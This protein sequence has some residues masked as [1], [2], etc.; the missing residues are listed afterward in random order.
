[1]L[2]ILRINYCEHIGHACNRMNIKV[3][4]ENVLYAIND[5]DGSNLDN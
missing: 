1:M 5:D 4:Y 2:T 3:N